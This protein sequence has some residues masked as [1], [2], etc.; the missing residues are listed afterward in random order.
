MTVLE[1]SGQFQNCSDSFRTVRTVSEPSGQF[2]NRPD[3]FRT[4]RTVSRPSGQFQKD[5]LVS[6]PPGR[7][8]NCPD[9]FRTVRTV[10]EPSVKFFNSL[11]Y[12]D[13][14]WTVQTV[15]IIII[16]FY[17]NMKELY[18]Y[19]LDVNQSLNR[20]IGIFGMIIFTICA[21]NFRTRKNFPDSNASLL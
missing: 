16:S 7:F 20:W 1:P 21:K 5:R 2:Q 11:D 4:V 6:E 12:L 10:L 18:S 19:C 15:V 14:N 13:K 17:F 3:S 9:S 8:L